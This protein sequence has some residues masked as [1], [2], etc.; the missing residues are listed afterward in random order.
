[1]D[2]FVQAVGRELAADPTVQLADDR[3]LAQVHA[4]WVIEAIGERV[5]SGEPA[6][7]VGE[8]SDPVAL[9]PPGAQ[10]APDAAAQG[11]RVPGAV[12]LVLRMHSRA[13][14]DHELNAVERG[15]VDDRR[16]HDL[17]RPQPLV[18]VVP[19][20]FRHVAER[21]VFD[22]DQH[23]VFALLVPDLIAGVPRVDEDRAD[24]ELVPR[25]AAAVAVAGG[26]VG[27][28]GGDSVTRE[29]LGDGVE[30]VARDELGEDPKP[31]AVAGESCRR[32]PA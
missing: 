18:R 6:P 3:V 30:P 17:L 29:T 10:S 14:G 15:L 31:L 11:V 1:V 4:Q 25:D 26:V 7:V 27:R 21:D 23:L 5:L 13:P 28:R 8:V 22:I 9:H 2:G 32:K 12:R 24:R 19:A 20:Q 16:L